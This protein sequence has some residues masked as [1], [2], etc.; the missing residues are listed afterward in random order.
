MLNLSN[1][2]ASVHGIGLYQSINIDASAGSIILIQGINGSGKSTLLRQIAQ[3]Q[4]CSGSNARWQGKPIDA[5][6]QVCFLGHQLG[7]YPHWTVQNMFNCYAKGLD[8][9]KEKQ[10]LT[11][12]GLTPYVK[13][14]VSQLSRGTQQK[15]ALTRFALTHRPLWVMDEPGTALDADAMVYLFDLMQAHKAAGGIVIFT[16]HQSS[17]GLAHDHRLDL[18]DF[19][20]LAQAVD[21]RRWL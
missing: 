12:L 1:Y 19:V 6:T 17:V 13:K 16:S 3:L 2:S 14:K 4:P 11:A 9:Q 15:L 5:S 7:L 10:V 8:T 18:A 21:D 20:P